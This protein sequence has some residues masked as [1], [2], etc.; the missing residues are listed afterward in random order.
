MERDCPD[1]AGQYDLYWPKIVRDEE[2]LLADFALDGSRL[3]PLTYYSLEQLKGFTPKGESFHSEEITTETVFGKYQVG[4]DFFK[5][6]SYNEYL[7]KLLAVIT[8]KLDRLSPRGHFKQL[9]NMQINLPKI[10]AVIDDYIRNSLFGKPF[11]PFVDENW[12]ILLLK[13]GGV[14]EHIIKEISKL[15]FEAQQS[16]QKSDAEI[17]KIYF[18]KVDKLSV[19]ENYSLALTKTIYERTA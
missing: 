2:E 1:T 19:R 11:N 7:Q 12:R 6:T 5:A 8:N 16:T 3:N 9:P 14:S 15:I 17:E 10:I 4:V 13:T 18:S